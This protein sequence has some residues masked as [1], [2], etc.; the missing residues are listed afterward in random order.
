MSNTTFVAD[1]PTSL[2]LDGFQL[3]VIPFN[4]SAEETAANAKKLYSKTRR[5]PSCLFLH[6]SFAGAASG[7]SNWIM[8]SLLKVSDVDAGYDRL[9]SGH[10]HKHQIVDG[11]LVYVGALLQHDFGERDYTPGFIH[12]HK[13]GTWKHI[14]NKESP[15]FVK[16]TSDQINCVN[17]ATKGDY[18]HVEWTGTA[19]GAASLPDM[20]DNLVLEIKP[21]VTTTVKRSAM[22]TTDSREALMAQ[23]VE[24]KTGKVDQEV[25][26]FGLKLL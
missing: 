16:T 7:P 20:F 4:P 13:D 12:V 17:Y 3:A 9:F 24:M 21:V 25:L 15:R 14:E 26:D 5:V 6:H 18:L 23:Y 19:E 22:K 8:P 1:K 2:S 11:K 10:Y